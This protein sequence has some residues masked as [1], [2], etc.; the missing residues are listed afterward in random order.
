MKLVDILNTKHS[1]PVVEYIL[2][3][4]ACVEEAPAYDKWKLTTIKVVSEYEEIVAVVW[5]NVSPELKNIDRSKP[6]FLCGM[7]LQSDWKRW[8]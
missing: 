8:K 5:G 6:V 4:P 7:V 1:E 3:E 2:T